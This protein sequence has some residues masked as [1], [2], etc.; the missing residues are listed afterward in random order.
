[1]QSFDARVCVIDWFQPCMQ[2]WHARGA[3]ACVP[4]APLRAYGRGD[5]SG[6]GAVQLGQIE[7]V[8]CTK[9]TLSQTKAGRQS[10]NLPSL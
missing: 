1:M 2:R 9:T 7:L 3:H 10:H 5:G 4:E 8:M 6:L